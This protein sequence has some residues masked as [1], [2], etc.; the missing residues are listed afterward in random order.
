MKIFCV[1]E[2]FLTDFDVKNECK[3]EL[4]D[5]NELSYHWFR[6]RVS[7]KIDFR[8]VGLLNGHADSVGLR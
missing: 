3:I 2:S 1:K 5:D 4:K 6:S 7:H 8:A